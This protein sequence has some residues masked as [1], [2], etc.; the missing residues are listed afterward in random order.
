MKL[1]III[2][3]LI[4]IGVI[5]YSN[6][7][8]NDFIWDDSGFVIKNEYI[9]NI[10]IFPSYF[11][12]KEALSEGLLSGE[13]YRPLFPLSLAIDYF[14]WG[15]NPF[16][17][18]LSNMIIHI[19]NAI[20]LFFIILNIT[21]QKYIGLFTSL[22]FLTHPIETETVTWIAGRSGVL[23]LFFFLWSLYFYIKFTREPVGQRL[24]AQD[25]L[26]AQIIKRQAGA[27]WR[28]SKGREDKAVRPWSLTKSGKYYLY[29]ASILSFLC[30][31]LSKESAASFPFII[32][33]YDIYYNRNEEKIPIRAARYF[34]YFLI[35]EMYII[36]RFFMIGKFAQTDYWG[37]SF[38]V[39]TISTIR[40]IVHY[41]KLLVYPV[42]LCADYLRFPLSYSIN[43]PKVIISIS[44]LAL[45][46]ITA[47][48]LRKKFKHISFSIFWF[49]TALCPSLN[50]IPVKI[51]IA[52][53]FLYAPSIGYCFALSFIIFLLV[54][55][56][57]KA[58]IL[59]IAVIIIACIIVGSY[60][61]LTMARNV[62]WSDEVF[63]WSKN[64][65]ASPNNERGYYNLAIA[66]L[67]K[68][69]DFEKAYKT[70]KKAVELAP[71][72]TFPRLVIASY[73]V[74]NRNY[75][76]AIEEL[77]KAEY[78]EPT[79]VEIYLYLCGIYAFLGKY[80]LAYKECQKGLAV[81]PDSIDAK[82]MVPIYYTLKGDND[83][84]I[85]EYE[86]L[87]KEPPGYHYR[88]HYAAAYLRLGELYAFSGDLENARKAWNKVV[89]EFGDQE[90]FCY[91]AKYNIGS[92]DLD[93]F[94][95]LIGPWQAELKRLAYYFIGVKKELEKDYIGA[96]KYYL[97]AVNVVS[98]ENNQVKL[99]ALLKLDAV[100]KLNA[101][102]S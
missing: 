1:S 33:L 10:K 49:F 65:S 89:R 55:K 94:L 85:K 84:A 7:L 36:L 54:K 63:F 69:K 90:W 93:N 13:N 45:V 66:Y 31:I 57:K 92:L 62:D 26:P 74:N 60:S 4:S 95:K 5:V 70:A 46:I 61:R 19:T 71:E 15:L 3:I 100:K 51:L 32:I 28:N 24:T 16:G 75:D 8:G 30:A 48:L 27:A 38:Y 59:R 99:R 78:L 25:F 11:K 79:F 44:I 83:I 81:K 97:E 47:I 80:D 23:S 41:L 91:I 37:G 82:L 6:S 64:V 17:Y 98:E 87:L 40:G 20:L 43:E 50:I 77:K 72:Y 102:K 2:F 68:E 58:P 12:S 18:H 96:E 39:S 21:R 101:D 73:H 86:N 9:K 22:F 14:F 67:S 76:L 34:L 29:F 53:R 88:L 56:L 35:L 42:N 52:E